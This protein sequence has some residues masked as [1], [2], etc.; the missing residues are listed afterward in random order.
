MLERMAEHT[1]KKHCQVVERLL[2][3]ELERLSSIYNGEQLNREQ[4]ESL[5]SQLSRVVRLLDCWVS[6][7]SGNLISDPVKMFHV[8]TLCFYN[9]VSSR[10][11][12]AQECG[13]EGFDKI[14]NYNYY[15]WIFWCDKAVTKNDTLAVI[16]ISFHCSEM[17]SYHFTV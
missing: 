6:W 13:I 9:A 11:F 15:V 7:K 10:L 4:V 12:T 8:G 14:T 3:Q 16:M 5:K 1:T 2:V 17:I